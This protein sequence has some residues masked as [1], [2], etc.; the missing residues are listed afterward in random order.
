MT[1]HLPIVRDDMN[2]RAEFDAHIALD[3]LRSDLRAFA[4][5]GVYRPDVQQHSTSQ[6]LPDVSGDA[7]ED[8]PQW[9]PGDTDPLRCD[10]DT[11]RTINVRRTPVGVRDGLAVSFPADPEAPKRPRVRSECLPRRIEAL[12]YIGFPDQ[13]ILAMLEARDSLPCSFASCRH[14]LRAGEGLSRES[15]FVPRPDIASWLMLPA[16]CALDEAERFDRDGVQPTLEVVAGYM[17]V[18]R[19]R[20][21]Q[22]EKKA[23]LALAM[24][25]GV[26]VK[27]MRKVLKEPDGR[28]LA[29]DT[30]VQRRRQKQTAQWGEA[31]RNVQKKRAKRQKERTAAKVRRAKVRALQEL[32]E[33][34]G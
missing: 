26:S 3:G 33:P 2:T 24:A 19:E 34:E 1:R 31:R 16:T 20:V 15:V 28:A 8:D 12:R 9:R 30:E 14:N 25:F 6:P 4:G 7:R 32:R 11:G 21:R 17:G 10:S 13:E 22:I 27:W 29:H 18:T 5:E 23:T